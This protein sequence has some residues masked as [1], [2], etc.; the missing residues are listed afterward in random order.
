MFCSQCGKQADD[1]ALFCSGCG[2]KLAT[3]MEASPASPESTPT[4]GQTVHSNEQV[5]KVSI[6]IQPPLAEG[7]RFRL[8]LDGAAVSGEHT[9]TQITLQNVERGTHTLTVTVVD[10]AGKERMRSDSV[11][12]YLRKISVLTLPGIPTPLPEIP[13]SPNGDGETNAEGEAGSEDSDDSQPNIPDD[14]PYDP[15]GPNYRP[16]YQPNYRPAPPSAR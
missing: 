9:A 16:T 13:D 11:T 12:F 2:E 1:G 14:N 4:E 6:S 5:L 8:F 15:T 10:Q 3:P 7:D